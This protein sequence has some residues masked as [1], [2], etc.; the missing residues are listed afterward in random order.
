MTTGDEDTWTQRLDRM[1]ADAESVAARKVEEARREEHEEWRKLLEERVQ[2]AASGASVPIDAG[3]A[4]QWLTLLYGGAWSADQPTQARRRAW[5]AIPARTDTDDDGREVWPLDTV[6]DWTVRI[7]FDVGADLRKMN[8]AAANGRPRERR[9][10][11]RD[12]RGTLYYPASRIE[13][14]ALAFESDLAWAVGQVETEIARLSRYTTAHV[15][16]EYIT[17]NEPN[18]NTVGACVESFSGSTKSARGGVLF[19]LWCAMGLESAPRNKDHRADAVHAATMF[20]A[21]RASTPANWI[22][23]IQEKRDACVRASE[24]YRRQS[25]PRHDLADSYANMA[26]SYEDT[27]EAA[28]N[29]L[30]RRR[31][32]PAKRS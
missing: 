24:H 13:F 4:E 25:P 14:E 21:R 9:G 28:Q 31:K 20:I 15:K 6:K 32:R 16:G 3:E 22:R 1:M 8:D 29:A 19:D 30:N 17:I 7:L 10:A 18:R 2:R 27:I 12:E 5:A 23:D 11:V 26:S